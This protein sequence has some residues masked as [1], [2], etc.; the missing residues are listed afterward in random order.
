MSTV[1]RSLHCI[2]DLVPCGI[3]V[4]LECLSVIDIVTNTVVLVNKAGHVL[5]KGVNDFSISLL[6]QA[7]SFVYLIFG[8]L[9]FVLSKAR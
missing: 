6:K 9:N 8:V 5:R 1:D 2:L 3:L 4:I 7:L